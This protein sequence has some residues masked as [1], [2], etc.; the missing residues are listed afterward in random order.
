M[1]IRI[2][3]Y[4]LAGLGVLVLFGISVLI[5]EFGH[6]AAARLLGMQ[7]DTFAIGFGPAIW[8]RRRGGTE[9]RVNWFPFGGYVALPQLDPAAMS[10]LQGGDGRT[11]EP[12]VWWKRVLVAVA[13]PFGNVVLAVFLAFLVAA[14]PWGNAH[15][16]FDH[17]GEATI[18]WV[19][20][21]GTS[22]AAGLRKGDAILAVGGVPV[23]TTDELIQE[24]HLQSG[25]EGHLVTLSVSNRVD[26]LAREATVPVATNAA[27]FY[28]LRDIR[29]AEICS[30]GDPKTNSPAA[31]AGVRAGD[32]VRRID[33]A[34]VFGFD[35]FTNHVAAAKGAPMRLEVLRDG[36]P[37]E[38]SLSAAYDEEEHRWLLGVPMNLVSL[39]PRQWMKYR[40]PWKQLTGDAGAIFRVLGGLVAPKHKGEAK[41]VAGALGG[42][43]LILVGIWQWLLVSFPVALGFIRLINVNLAV[44][45]LL[46]IP[47]LDGGHVLFALG[48]AVFR[49]KPPKALVEGIMNVFLVLLLLLFAWLFF[50]DFSRIL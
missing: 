21:G 5:H 33:G 10:T 15:P 2:F 7:A 36:A 18:G 28:F 50:K 29:M 30:V 47:I 27:G 37:Q 24:C 42:P 38:F 48:E 16:G 32:L 22:E 13:G 39:S 26:G 9:Y 43:V 3:H 31:L 1:F 4:L 20:P 6:F 23:G 8:K 17:L 14:L 45:N 19:T 49:R 12:A 46:P 35:D 11:L 34:F 41:K 40:N 44:L 25:A